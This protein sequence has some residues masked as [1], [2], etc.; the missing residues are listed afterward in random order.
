MELSDSIPSVISDD[1]NAI[2]A[3][4]AAEEQL[5]QFTRSKNANDV[6]RAKLHWATYV[7]VLTALEEYSGNVDTTKLRPPSKKIL[8]VPNAPI[9][10]TYAQVKNRFAGKL[11]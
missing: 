3:L 9:S 5:E 4:I 6:P 7:R 8:Y 1:T 10:T 2:D 11:P